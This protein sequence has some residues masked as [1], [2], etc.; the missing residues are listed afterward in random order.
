[1]R[2]GRRHVL[3]GWVF[4]TL[5][6]WILGIVLVL[7]LAGL[8]ELLRLEGQFSVGLGMGLGVG[9]AQW[10]VGRRWF[11]ATAGWVWASALGLGAPFLLSDLVGRPWGTTAEYW[12]ILLHAAFGG[13]LVGLWQWRI[14]R[15]RSAR[16]HW[17]VAACTGGWTLAVVTV[18]VLV[19]P[20]HPDTALQ[21]WRNVIAIAS[22]GA[23]LGIVTGPALA[24]ILRPSQPAHL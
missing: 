16:G 8:G 23:T 11:G 21:A 9:L 19:H 2:F 7:L 4:A 17:W 12:L 10:R 20:G 3:G 6:G 22:G 24:W 18:L 5:G 14:L 15:G 13:V 1:M